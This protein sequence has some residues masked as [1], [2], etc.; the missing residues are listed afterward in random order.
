MLANIKFTKSSIF[1]GTKLALRTNLTFSFK[2]MCVF[3]L[4]VGKSK[5]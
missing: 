3:N 4:T 5:E 1:N 2:P